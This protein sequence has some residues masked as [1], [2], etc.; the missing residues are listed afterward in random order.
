M[1]FPSTIGCMF[2]NRAIRQ[3][4]VW[5]TWGRKESNLLEWILPSVYRRRIVQWD[6]HR[7]LLTNLVQKPFAS[8][9]Q[10]QPSPFSS[11]NR[12]SGPLSPVLLANAMLHQIP[13]PNW[14]PFA[15]VLRPLQQGWGSKAPLGVPL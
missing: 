3:Y 7:W 2:E 11:E 8:A 6:F 13:S 5:F 1:R 14:A 12:R 15:S 4:T 10:R 9:H